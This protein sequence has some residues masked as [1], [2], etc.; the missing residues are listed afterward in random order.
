MK[1][2][3]NLTLN[4]QISSTIKKYNNKLLIKKNKTL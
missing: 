1:L 4:N 2:D 3:T